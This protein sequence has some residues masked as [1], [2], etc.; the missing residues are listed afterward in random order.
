MAASG[1]AARRRGGGAARDAVARRR[2]HSRLMAVVSFGARLRDLAASRSDD[3]ALVVVDAEGARE[4]LTW[5]SFD[6]WS[7]ALAHDL[8]ARGTAL[9]TTVIVGFRNSVEH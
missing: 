8:V 6:S 3:I 1:R 7:E 5:S 9:G 4:E 2:E